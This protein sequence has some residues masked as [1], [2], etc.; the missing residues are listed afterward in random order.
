M[1]FVM[2]GVDYWDGPACILVSGNI[3]LFLHMS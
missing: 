2:N 1:S 3:H